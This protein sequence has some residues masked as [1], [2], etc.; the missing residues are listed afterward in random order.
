MGRSIPMQYKCRDGAL[1]QTK[2]TAGDVFQVHPVGRQHSGSKLPFVT[3]VI[4]IFAKVERVFI[5]PDMVYCFAF[6]NGLI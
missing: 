5:D 3:Q 2:V 4:Y 1:C 6:Q